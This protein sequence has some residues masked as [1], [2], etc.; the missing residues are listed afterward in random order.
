[1]YDFEAY[2]LNHSDAFNYLDSHY[3]SDEAKELFDY[4]VDLHQLSKEQIADIKLII[5]DSKNMHSKSVE[6]ALEFERM[7][8]DPK[9]KREAMAWEREAKERL[10]REYD[11][12]YG[13]VPS[14]SMDDFQSVSEQL[15]T[16][17]IRQDFQVLVAEAR[18]REAERRSQLAQQKAKL[19]TNT[20]ST[21]RASNSAKKK[22]QQVASTSRSKT[23]KA[24][25]QSSSS[26]TKETSNSCWNAPQNCVATS[27]SWSGSNKLIS[28]FTNN[29]SARIYIHYCNDRDNGNHDCG[30]SGLAPGN[31][32]KWVTSNANG[33]YRWEYVGS[34]KAS[35][36]WTCA[37][38]VDNWGK[39]FRSQSVK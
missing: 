9:A 1:M 29:C 25:S 34:T 10:D 39:N 26:R 36:D 15:G 8:W 20:T 22:A 31:T 32:K 3:M 6:S 4:Y 16:D 38:K 23:G 37:N 2:S 30:E 11:A 14:L 35:E 12:N 7:M 27:S 24:G 33:K 13:D 21:L 5:A 19:A 17:K 18:Q 28:K